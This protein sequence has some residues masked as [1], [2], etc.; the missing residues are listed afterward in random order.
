MRSNGHHRARPAVA[1][2]LVV[3]L[4]PSVAIARTNERDGSLLSLAAVV[5]VL[6][7]GVAGLVLCTSRR[8]LC[9]GVVGACFVGAMALYAA[10]NPKVHS[11]GLGLLLILGT[12]LLA[13]FVMVGAWVFAY[14]GG[15]EST[16]GRSEADTQ[17]RSQRR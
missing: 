6:W 11:D 4:L 5:L 2:L 14:A 10:L 1:A 15:N 7:L 3:V 13:A 16:P 9:I 12:P 8:N 17:T